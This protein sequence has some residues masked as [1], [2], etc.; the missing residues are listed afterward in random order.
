MILNLCNVCINYKE[1]N[2]NELTLKKEQI[3]NFTPYIRVKWT[4]N[5]SL[6]MT[7]QPFEHLYKI[8]ITES[9][10]KQAIDKQLKNVCHLYKQHQLH[11]YAEKFNLEN[12]MD[13]YDE[14]VR[15]IES[16]LKDSIDIGWAIGNGFTYHKSFYERYAFNRLCKQIA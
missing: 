16:K 12:S 5:P 9:L 8:P 11:Y 1:V 15:I 7:A 13:N 14:L 4:R 10:L 6:L 2:M 3:T